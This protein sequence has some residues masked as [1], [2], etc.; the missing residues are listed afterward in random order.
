MMIPRPLKLVT[1]AAVTGFVALAAA[2]LGAQV[3]T[4][5]AIASLID[6]RNGLSVAHTSVDVLSGKVTLRGIAVDSGRLSVRI[7]ALRLALDGG[8]SWLPSIAKLSPVS[9]AWA[10]PSGD[11]V[12]DASPE[13]GSAPPSLAAPGTASAENVVI[14]Y[15][16][17]TYTIPKIELA[18]TSLSNADLAALL[19]PTTAESVEARLRRLDAASITVPE[20]KADTQS[21]DF[22]QHWRQTQLLLAN[23]VHGRA[24]LG[25]AAA[26][27]LKTKSGKGSTAAEV[28]SVEMA[29][30]DMG[31]IVHV[32]A[33]ARTDDNEA[34][35]ALADSFA[36][37]AVKLTS[38]EAQPVLTVASLKETGLKARPLA[39]VTQARSVLLAVGKPGEP[40]VDAFL[41]DIVN[42]LSF[43][44]LQVEDV[45]TTPPVEG[46]N[47]NDLL[48]LARIAIGG[49]H[50]RQVGDLAVQKFRFEAPQGRVVLAGAE[51]KGLTLPAS[52][53][54]KTLPLLNS[55]DLSGLVY[56]FNVADAG[57]PE[58]RLNF[59]VARA[60]FAVPGAK[61]D[62]LPPSATLTVDHVEVAIRPDMSPMLLTLGYPKLD[63]SSRLASSYDAASQTLKIN[64]WRMEGTGMGSTLLKLDL[65]KVTDAI[66]S[67]DADAQ[68]AAAASVVFKGFD[69]T[70][71]DDGLV[72]RLLAFKATQDGVSVA[73][74]RDTVIDMVRNKLPP[75]AGDP[76]K[77]KP[78]EEAVARFIADPKTPLHIAVSAAN[79]LGA[80]DAGLL[81]DPAALLDQLTVAAGN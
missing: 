55:F 51:A 7:S 38:G 19:D 73:Q 70:L 61:I 64:D 54:A 16:N 39:L 32:A 81:N 66:V 41:D 63:I 76:P 24:A 6:G 43:T 14:T 10:F 68:K 46:P 8:R 5:L 62:A 80:A 69:L 36:V 58:R 17:V 75:M 67:R 20:I 42:S 35:K 28:G 13:A 45:A 60:G 25:S 40:A 48:Q 26:G 33:T 11:A 27:T 57:Q 34:Q 77:L 52:L 4:R 50:D 22:E 65:G 59:E 49:F 1:A 31:Q 15:D 2:G 30:I 3:R 47:K 21:G 12:P 53:G 71:H 56:D 23:V 29:G 37:S 9:P 78:L 18:G 79:G 74:A 72:D 44:L